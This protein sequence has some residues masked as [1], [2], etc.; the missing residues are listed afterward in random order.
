MEA[1]NVIKFWTH[2]IGKVSKQDIRSMIILKNFNNG[3]EILKRYSL[4]MEE[5]L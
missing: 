3:E 4:E 2:N 1:I 5:I